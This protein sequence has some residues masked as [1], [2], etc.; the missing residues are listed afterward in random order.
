MLILLNKC[1]EEN[2]FEKLNLI[3]EDW[4]YTKFCLL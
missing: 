2:K 3:N 1:K 4:A